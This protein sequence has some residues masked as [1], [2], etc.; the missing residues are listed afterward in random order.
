MKWASELGGEARKNLCHAGTKSLNRVDRIHRIS[1]NSWGRRLLINLPEHP[2]KSCESC[3]RLPVLRGLIAGGAFLF[4]HEFIGRKFGV[5]LDLAD[6]P[7]FV[8]RAAFDLGQPVRQVEAADALVLAERPSVIDFRGFIESILSFFPQ[9]FALFRSAFGALSRLPALSGLRALSRLP[10]LSGLRALSRLPALSGL[11]ALSRLPALSGLSGL[12]PLSAL[13]SALA[14]ESCGASRPSGATSSSSHQ[15]FSLIAETDQLICLLI[16]VEAHG[17]AVGAFAVEHIEFAAFGA[18]G[19][20]DESEFDL[21]RCGSGQQPAKQDLVH[22]TALQRLE[23]GRHRR[24]WPEHTS[25]A[26]RAASAPR[27]ARPAASPV[28]KT[29]SASHSWNEVVPNLTAVEGVDY[30]SELG[31]GRLFDLV[32]HEHLDF[33]IGF[34]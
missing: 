17:E 30:C 34:P 22:L 19:F 23:I 13:T 14:S 9:A 20:T 8:G 2:E 24:I 26:A 11:R 31:A 5:D 18:R 4:L 7:F 32:R 15:L 21:S 25:R 3:L 33:E 1:Q 27:A 28:S 12:R 16:E 29:A 10:A 6:L